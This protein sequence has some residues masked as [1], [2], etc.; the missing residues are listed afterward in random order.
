MFLQCSLQFSFFRRLV[1]VVQNF[2]VI[3]GRHKLFTQNSSQQFCTLKECFAPLHSRDKTS[4]LV[5]N[6][7]RLSTP[8]KDF[9]IYVNICFVSSSWE[10]TAAEVIMLSFSFICTLKQLSQRTW[11]FIRNTCS[12]KCH[13]HLLSPYKI[14]S[15]R[16]SQKN[17]EF[18]PAS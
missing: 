12:Q 4:L 10:I 14:N 17:A 9:L 15:P 5:I 13:N 3:D 16:P 11:K 8:G 6:D 2:F 1:N 7:G 18:Y